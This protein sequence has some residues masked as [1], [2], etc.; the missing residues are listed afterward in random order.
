[1]LLV[2]TIDLKGIQL[3]ID[4]TGI[5]AST[6]TRRSRP[7]T[8]TST[9]RDDREGGGMS[10][11]HLTG[12]VVDELLAHG[13]KEAGGHVSPQV[14]QLLRAGLDGGLDGLEDQVKALAQEELDKLEQKG[15]EELDKLEQKGQEELDELEAQANEA[16][17]K[18]QDKAR[19]KLDDLLKKESS[20][21]FGDG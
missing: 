7:R 12:Y 5:R 19:A 4:V 14:M 6:S 9:S 21:L 13:L 18:E 10:V 1:M 11:G 8:C 3:S 15:Q 2:D 17:Q 16:I 20:K